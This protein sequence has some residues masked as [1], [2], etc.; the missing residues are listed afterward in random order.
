LSRDFTSSPEDDLYSTHSN[1]PDDLKSSEN[2]FI[3]TLEARVEELVGAKKKETDKIQ[4]L[5]TQLRILIQ[6]RHHS[7]IQNK[8]GIL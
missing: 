1:S 2:E 5:E 4:Q 6:V 8:Y 7:Q 3:Q